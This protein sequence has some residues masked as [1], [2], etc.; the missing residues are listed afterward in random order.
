MHVAAAI[1][2]RDGGVV[3]VLQGPPGGERFWALPGGVVDEGELVPEALVREVREE[4]G[5]EIAG[6]GRLAFVRQVD[7][8]R[9]VPLIESGG[10]G[11]GYLATIW[12]FE[13]DDWRGELAPSDP[14]GVVSEAR[15]VPRAE[16]IELLRRTHWLD[17]VADYLEGRVKPGTLRFERWSDGGEDVVS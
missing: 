10:P 13:V 9:P 2:R 3:L 6:S 17:L 1:M 4:T 12:V 5:L 16:A 8:R 11:V 7:E 15:L 14:D